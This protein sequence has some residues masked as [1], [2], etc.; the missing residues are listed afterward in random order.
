MTLAHR[1]H[2]AG[3]N[4]AGRAHRARAGLGSHAVLLVHP[5]ATTAMTSV[6]AALIQPVS[7]AHQREGIR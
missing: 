1:H 5:A 2:P 4:S 7:S 6:M 3:G